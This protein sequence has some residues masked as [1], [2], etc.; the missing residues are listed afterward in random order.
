[1]KKQIT[2]RIDEDLLVWFKSKG[3]GY[4]KLIHKALEKYRLFNT[5][6][7]DV[8]KYYTDD[9]VLPTVTHPIS[10]DTNMKFK[11]TTS[12][13]DNVGFPYGWQKPLTPMP[14]TGKGKK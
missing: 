8:E 4:H 13:V 11:T 1:M 9:V 2:L 10:A 7:Y 12:S 3:K 14:K 5:P 6:S